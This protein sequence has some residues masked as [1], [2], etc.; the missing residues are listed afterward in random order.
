MTATD[1]IFQEGDPFWHIAAGDWI[2]ENAQIPL[3][4]IWSFT[5]GD[6]RW[7]NHSWAWDVLFSWIHAQGNWHA[8][9]AINA[10]IYSATLVVVFAHCKARAGSVLAALI[11]VFLMTTLTQINLR[12]LQITMLAVAA[13]AWILGHAARGNATSRWLLALPMMMWV[14]ANMHGGFI[15]GLL[16]IGA[17][18]AFACQR[19]EWPLLRSLVVVGMASVFVTLCNPY[20]M[21]IYE[22]VWRPFSG[23][24]SQLVAEWQPLTLTPI[25]LLTVSYALLFIVM[26]PRRVMPEILPIERALAYGFLLLAVTAQRHLAI[27]AILAAP[28]LTCY[29]RSITQDLEQTALMLRLRTSW[30]ALA[31]K[32]VAAGMM[33]ATLAVAIWL[34]THSASRV[35][36]DKFAI[37]DL[38]EEIDFIRSDY[39]KARILNS[40]DLGGLVIYQGRGAVK[41]FVDSRTTTAYP[42]EVMEDVLRFYRGEPGWDDIV[43][44]YRIDGI[45]LLN[46]KEKPIIDR[47]SQR[48]GWRQVLATKETTLFMR[49]P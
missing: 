3:R 8:V 36:G 12:P 34:P 19:R 32:P 41:L 27:F 13:F 20:G 38:S 26:I 16:L 21:Y 49:T 24:D 47:L 46:E 17:Y 5:A 23:V 14:W 33:I 15:V 1:A 39:P 48:K 10:I 28:I 22:A 45:W 4:D 30:Q 9:I 29:I 37:T 31:T 40:F 42:K 2:R 25:A 43:S 11:T 18:A 7:L 6:T 44:R 35:L